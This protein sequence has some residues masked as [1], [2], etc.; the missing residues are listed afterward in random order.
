MLRICWES[1]RTG[2]E[3]DLAAAGFQGIGAAH[4]AVLQWPSPRGMRVTSLASRARMSRQAINYLI[5]ELELKG[6]LERR[7]DP[8][9]GRARNVHLTPRGESAI[10]AIRASVRRQERAWEK[11]LGPSRFAQF[12][13]ALTELAAAGSTK[14]Q[15]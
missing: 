11:R 14:T 8:S 1:V 5:R 4:L 3:R 6:Y 13:D 12:R 7:R 2:I 9:D 10:R 15:H